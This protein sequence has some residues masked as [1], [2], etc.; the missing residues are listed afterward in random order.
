MLAAAMSGSKAISDALIGAGAHWTVQHGF[1]ETP[2]AL[3]LVCEHSTLTEHILQTAP[4]CYRPMELLAATLQSVR[5]GNLSAFDSILGR[6]GIPSQLDAWERY[7]EGLCLATSASHGHV[8]TLL[9]L[10][11]AGISLSKNPHS[12]VG[13][14]LAARFNIRGSYCEVM[15][16][17]ILLTAPGVSV[18]GSAALGD[19]TDTIHL[20]LEL[21]HKPNLDDLVAT[22]EHAS[23]K[24]MELLFDGHA[25]DVASGHDIY[26]GKM[27]QQFIKRGW[28]AL[29]YLLLDAG[30]DVNTPPVYRPQKIGA[31][32]L[33]Q[34]FPRTA[35]QVAVEQG[36]IC[37]V[38]RLIGLGPRVNAP[39]M[40]PCGATALQGAGD[41]GIGAASELAIWEDMVIEEF[42][43]WDEQSQEGD[44]DAGEVKTRH[45]MEI[46]LPHDE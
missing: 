45:F 32:R 13:L 29:A 21:G 16:R 43:N 9:K 31:M 5:T 28:N 6:R 25:V 8:S 18:V 27:M 3:A 30:V 1:G 40:G 26:K 20:L 34:D 10:L 22:A 41:I 12:R 4:P 23:L 19:Q 2:L 7:V 11:D 42:V 33:V 14:V 39:A 24:T 36:D 37:L 46:Y 44:N 38:S 15:W 35:L 17:R